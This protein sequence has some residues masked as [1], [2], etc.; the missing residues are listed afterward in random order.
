MTSQAAAAAAYL[1]TGIPSS[2]AGV[3]SCWGRGG[4]KGGMQNEGMEVGQ[5]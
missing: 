1:E 3:R 2:E 4:G 5:H